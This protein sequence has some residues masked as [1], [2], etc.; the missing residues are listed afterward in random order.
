MHIYIAYM[1][2]NHI[3]IYMIGMM[4]PYDPAVCFETKPWRC[5]FFRKSRWIQTACGAQPQD[6]WVYHE[7]SIYNS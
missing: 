1:K 6:F 7:I 2:Y 4:I 3:Y 5:K